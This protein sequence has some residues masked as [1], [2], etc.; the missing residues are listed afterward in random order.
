MNQ[1][2]Q[3]S[4]KEAS[5][6]V[7]M[8]RKRGR[9][10]KHP[11]QNL[12]HRDNA[13]PRFQNLNLRENAHADVPPGFQGVNGTRLRPVD[14]NNNT[15]DVVVGQV[16]HGVIEAAFDAGYLLNV[17]VGNS[18]TTLR[19]VVLKHG[20]YVPVSAH[21]DVAPNVQMVRRNE[22][23]FPEE[24]YSQVPVSNSQSKGRSEQLVNPYRNGTPSL[25]TSKGKDGASISIQTASPAFSKNIYQPVSLSNGPTV[26]KQPSSV[27]RQAIHPEASKVKPVTE[28]VIPSNGSKSTDPVQHV[29]NQVFPLQA[30]ISP[31]GMLS[32][33]PSQVLLEAEAKSMKLPGMPFEKL[34]TEVIKRIHPPSHSEEAQNGNRDDDANTDQ[35]LSIEPLQ[36][37]QPNV[38]VHSA[39]L[40]KTFEN[41]KTGKMTE[42]LRAVQENMMDQASQFEESATVGNLTSDKLS[43]VAEVGDEE[44]DHSKKNSQ[45]SS[46]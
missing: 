35:A 41:F 2:N 1:D 11:R 36:A 39:S 3:V 37:V 10:R 42:L 45:P 4:N 46:V 26:T 21:N 20:H 38:N 9:P 8:K 6:N 27:P 32:Q 12:N 29:G 7:T 23:P 34:L 15:N 28:A 31:Q 33:P 14:G 5:A 40:S 30:Q 18:E 43:P 19:G 16:V 24:N 25:G 22:I 44:N 13:V 17:K